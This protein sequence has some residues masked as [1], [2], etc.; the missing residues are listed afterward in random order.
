VNHSKDL[1]ASRAALKAAYSNA[2]ARMS[3]ILFEADPFGLNLGN[4]TDEYDFEVSRVLPRLRDCETVED[5][6][7]LLYLEFAG[8]FNAAIAGTPERYRGAAQRIWT[9]LSDWH[10]GEKQK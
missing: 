10:G 2:F 8:C 4:N 7:Q 1:R 3:R 5:I 9:E 6:E